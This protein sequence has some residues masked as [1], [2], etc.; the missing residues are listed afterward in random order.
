MRGALLALIFAAGT[1]LVLGRKGWTAWLAASLVVAMAAV[2]GF[3]HVADVG[4]IAGNA[5]FVSGLALTTV[6]AA[7]SFAGLVV[8]VRRF[9]PGGP[10]CA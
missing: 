6:L 10:S 3:A 2:Q 7:A 4:T 9:R 5:A 8:L 1:M